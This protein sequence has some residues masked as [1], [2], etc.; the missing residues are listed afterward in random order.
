MTFELYAGLALV[1][2]LAAI[3]VALVR[4]GKM[5]ERGKAL[6][7]EKR[8]RVIADEIDRD[9]ARNPDPLGELRDD[10]QRRP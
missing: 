2:V 10:W 6:Q 9:V 8:A 4:S 3:A 7:S 5:A 1:V